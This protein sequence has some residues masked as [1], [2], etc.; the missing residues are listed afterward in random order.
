MTKTV[1]EDVY[2]YDSG[3]YYK[4]KS[5]RQAS[6]ASRGFRFVFG[7]ILAM[8]CHPERQWARWSQ[9]F[10]LQK[11]D[12]DAINI[13]SV[14]HILCNVATRSIFL[15]PMIVAIS[16]NASISSLDWSKGNFPVRK[17]RNIIPADQ[18]SM[19][20]GN[21]NQLVESTNEWVN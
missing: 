20:S 21:V 1:V 17:K 6:V 4:G 11:S 13:S 3:G 9:K 2:R 14:M 19:A 5:V 15:R 8:A 18:T 16:I 10:D 12:E 7:Q